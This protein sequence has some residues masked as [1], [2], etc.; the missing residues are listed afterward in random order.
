[1]PH[2]IR[3]EF[4]NKIKAGLQRLFTRLPT[5][6]ADLIAMLCD[7]LQCLHLAQK[8]LRVATDVARTHLIGDDLA[9]GVH[10]KRAALSTPVILDVDGKA[11]T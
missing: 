7:E 1:M 11:R 6:G 3:L 5:C 2:S 9:L 8:L 4:A 10:D